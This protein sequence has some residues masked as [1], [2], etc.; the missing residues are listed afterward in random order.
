MKSN[1]IKI[2]SSMLLSITILYIIFLLAFAVIFNKHFEK[3][4]IKA[5]KTE[6]RF[7]TETITSAAYE[8]AYS[9]L[10]GNIFFGSIEFLEV[11]DQYQLADTNDIF[12]ESRKNIKSLLSYCK[13]EKQR[14]HR[15]EVLQLKENKNH[16]IIMEI[17]YDQVLWGEEF[18]EDASYAVIIYINLS[19]I[20]HLSKKIAAVSLI[21]FI[22]AGVVMYFLGLLLGKKIENEK[23]RQNIFF[24]NAS[25]ELK[26][27]LMSIQ[28]YAE[29]IEKETVNVKNAA[30]IILNESERMNALVNELLDILKLKSSA[31]PLKKENID[32][33]ELIYDVLGSL[34]PILQK[35][36]IDLNF[37]FDE[38]VIVF[39]GDENGLRKA[40][41]NLITNAI[42]YVDKKIMISCTEA[43]GKIVIKVGN[44]GKKADAE[45]LQHI[46]ERFYTG[47]NGKTGIG[48]ALSKEIIE[49]QHG[50]LTAQ[51]IEN[52]LEFTIELINRK[53]RYKRRRKSIWQ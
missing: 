12:R 32:V 41:S 30:S 21:G 23:K 33:K 9:E 45:I 29:G 44:D 39:Y 52:G 7:T 17:D 42:R 49:K 38:K 53:R 37:D 26:T 47:D 5:L 22:I 16:Y 4:A 14:L 11:T 15:G 51:N 48:L 10:T 46:F 24:Q 27:P 19:T 13:D 40:F 31:A 2:V 34:E 3:E 18:S 50:K 8:K 28:G 35:K 36:K 43:N 25:H 6:K 20:N 1:T